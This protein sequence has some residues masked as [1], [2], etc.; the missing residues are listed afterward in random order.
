M[1]PLGGC[2]IYSHCVYFLSFSARL[3]SL[4]GVQYIIYLFNGEWNEINTWGWLIKT[5]ESTGLIVLIL[6]A[7][8]GEG[9][10]SPFHLTVL[11]MLAKKEKLIFVIT[12]VDI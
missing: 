5:I 12:A 1:I 2:C 8:Q 3:F 10:K 4:F 6:F 9:G 7:I 11:R